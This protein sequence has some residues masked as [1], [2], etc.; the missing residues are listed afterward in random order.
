MRKRRGTNEG[1]VGKVTSHAGVG[2]ISNAELATRK[3]GEE[4]DKGKPGARSSRRVSRCR[5]KKRIVFIYARPSIEQLLT[6][7][8][9]TSL[10]FLRRRSQNTLPFKVERVQGL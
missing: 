7:Q 4:I 6:Y 10:H 2:Y 5:K 9:S 3:S 1:G 8:S